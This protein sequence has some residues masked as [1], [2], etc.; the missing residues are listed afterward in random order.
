[1]NELE[2]KHYTQ[3]CFIHDQKH[4]HKIKDFSTNKIETCTEIVW[5]KKLI[6]SRKEYLQTVIVLEQIYEQRLLR[7]SKERKLNEKIN[8]LM[9]FRNTNPA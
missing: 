6:P 2:H 4:G 7:S 1:M 9:A 5:V 3:I 8:V